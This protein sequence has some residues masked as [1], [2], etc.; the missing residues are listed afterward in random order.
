MSLSSSTWSDSVNK[1]NSTKWGKG[2][3]KEE[4]GE[5]GDKE[6]EK[7]RGR[8]RGNR[9]DFLVKLDKSN[10]KFNSHFSFRHLGQMTCSQVNWS[11]AFPPE[12]VDIV[13][14]KWRCCYSKQWILHVIKVKGTIIAVECGGPPLSDLD[15]F[16][17]FSGIATKEG[18]EGVKMKTKM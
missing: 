17:D 4:R 10:E 12:L 18:K 5:R 14:R 6:E 1:Q 8:R 3:E 13:S 9:F 7:E 11:T 16:S 2:K 15:G